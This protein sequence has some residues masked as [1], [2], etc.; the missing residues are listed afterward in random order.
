[1]KW[2]RCNLG[3]GC[4]GG[5]PTHPSTGGG[6]L[7][8]RS[9]KWTSPHRGEF[10]LHQK[11]T[12][13]ICYS[14]AH[15]LWVYSEPLFH[16]NIPPKLWNRHLFSAFTAFGCLKSQCWNILD[17][18]KPFFFEHESP[19]KNGNSWAL[20]HFLGLE[21]SFMAKVYPKARTLP[22][23]SWS[24]NFWFYKPP[25]VCIGPKHKI[26]TTGLEFKSTN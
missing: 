12:D 26:Q 17:C 22:S 15:C 3:G 1:M 16:I 8:L 18:F 25:L 19:N 10:S 7:R 14:K 9:P 24:V 21:T 5:L 13:R 4:V 23:P 2:Q 11:L 20:N 6:G